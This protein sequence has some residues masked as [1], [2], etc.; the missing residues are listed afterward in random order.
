MRAQNQAE[1]KAMNMIHDNILST[2]GNTPI[3]K[4]SRMSPSGTTI[5]A[6]LEAFNPAGSVKDRLAA[7]IIE[8]AENSGKLRPGQTVI[9]ATSG[10]TGIGLAMVCAAKNY[11]LVIVMPE[12]ASLE[13]RKLMRFYGAQVVLTPAAE[14]GTGM[15]LKA[16]ELAEKHGWFLCRQF[17]TLVNADI[18]ARTT[19]REILHAFEGHSL[20]YFVTGTGTGGTL[21]GVARV[22]KAE[23]PHTRI[24]ACEPD[25]S[26]L[27]SSGV[28]QEFDANGLPVQS[29]AGF[30]PHPMQGWSPDFIPR[31]VGDAMK[32]GLVDEIRPVSGTSAIEVAR[33]LAKSEG[34]LTGITG[35][36]TLAAA[37]ALAR[38]TGPGTS[39]LCMLPDTGERYMSTVLFENI[40]EEM[41][42][43]E[44]AISRSTPACQFNPAPI[45]GR[46][47][48]SPQYETA[49]DPVAQRQVETAI[50][51]P[52]NPVVMFAMSWCEF[53]W[54][55]RRFFD[56]I[57]IRYISVDIDTPELQKNGQDTEIR[58]VLRAI[59]GS[60][61][62]P[63]I[64]IGGT[65]FGGC[66]DL[67]EAWKAGHV[68]KELDRLGVDFNAAA[69][70]EPENLL[71][72]WVHSRAGAA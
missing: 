34:V 19:A 13:R 49:L 60:P 21:S 51:D 30:R 36:A 35:G 39:I 3:V 64:F 28:M 15:M 4:L 43:S 67:M 44:E 47:V 2:I 56:I 65:H 40:A 22:L 42:L 33:E 14:K 45:A 46:V 29:H 32:Q 68:Q 27:L 69:C 37:I 10:N 66:T 18:H 25:N 55:L 54:S 52:D 41:S 53:C 48:V 50:T 8:E 16:M 59:T 58:K 70:R 26:A 61:T 62:I 9:E 57:G 12:S 1:E 71:P 7:A 38:R 31:I 11:P 23:S 17:E 24:I 72:K 5:Y 6:K 63:Q 20:D